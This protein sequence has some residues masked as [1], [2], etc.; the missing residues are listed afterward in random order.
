MLPTMVKSSIEFSRCADA[1]LA[2]WTIHRSALTNDDAD[3]RRVAGETGR[4]RS[5]PVDPQCSLIRTGFSEPRAIVAQRRTLVGD[6][7]GENCDN[8]R[9]QQMRVFDG[10]VR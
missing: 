5:T 4:T 10:N 1:R 6:R 7:L 3:E 2:L 8:V 9:V